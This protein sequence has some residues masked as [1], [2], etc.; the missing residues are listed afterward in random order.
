[1][2]KLKKG[3]VKNKSIDAKN[4][5]MVKVINNRNNQ[6]KKYRVEV[7]QEF[8]PGMSQKALKKVKP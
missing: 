2:A 8:F 5:K 1:M 3:P 6:K 7:E 4:T